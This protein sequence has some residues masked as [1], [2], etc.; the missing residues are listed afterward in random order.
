MR[1]ITLNEKQ[2]RRCEIATRL[3]AKK[4]TNREAGELL[5]LSNRQV[6][7]IRQRYEAD[8]LAT[9]VHG[10]Q[11]QPSPRRTAAAIIDRLRELAGPAGRYHDFNVSH[12]AD[13]LARRRRHQ[14]PALYSLPATAYP[15]DSPTTT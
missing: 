2:Q 12:L 7:R 15:S 1:T 10:N 3:I 6:R 5:G 14:D 11:D 9:V 4:I 8:G 13:L